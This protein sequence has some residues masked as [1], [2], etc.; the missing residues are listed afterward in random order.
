MPVMHLLK[1]VLGITTLVLVQSIFT[2]AFA[3]TPPSTV[4]WN[5]GIQSNGDGSYSSIVGG[6]VFTAT[7]YDTTVDVVSTQTMSDSSQ[8]STWTGG[9]S[10]TGEGFSTNWYTTIS[11]NNGEKLNYP[12]IFA[13][14]FSNNFDWENDF[15]VLDIWF[16]PI[17]FSVL[18]SSG[19]TAL[20]LLDG[21]SGQNLENFV[22]GTQNGGGFFKIGVDT[23][24]QVNPNTSAGNSSNTSQN[25]EFELN[26]T[27]AT[28]GVDQTTNPQL[29]ISTSQPLPDRLVFQ[30]AANEK[31][32]RSGLVSNS[33]VNGSD[34]DQ[35]PI[36]IYPTKD[37]QSF[38]LPF[39][40]LD[41]Q[42][43][44]N[45]EI[46]EICLFIDPQDSRAN[47][48]IG[49]VTF[50]DYSFID[51]DQDAGTT[52]VCWDFQVLDDDLVVGFDNA[53]SSVIEGDTGDTTVNLDISLAGGVST[54]SALTVPYTVSTSSTATGGGTD[55]TLSTSNAQI[56][57][58]AS[59]AQIS[60]TIE[61]DVL[62][63]VNEDIIITLSTPQSGSGY[64]LSSNSTTHTL[65]ITDNDA[66]PALSVADVTVSEGVTSGKATV[67]V[68]LD[69]VSG[70]DVQFDY[71][72]ADN[73]ATE[74]ADYTATS[75]SGVTIT[76]GNQSVTFDVTIQD[77]TLSEGDEDLTITLSNE[78]NA[79]LATSDASA[80]LTIEDNDGLPS[81]TIDSSVS[82]NEGLD[83]ET[84]QPNI[85]VR[86]STASSS[87]IT[88]N[89]RTSNGSATDLD[90]DVVIETGQ[91]TFQPNQTV[92]VINPTVFGDSIYEANETFTVELFNAVNAQISSSNSISIVNIIDDDPMPQI[93]IH[94]VGGVESEGIAQVEIKL[95][96][97]AGLDTRF[98]YRTNDI[99]AVNGT[100]YNGVTGEAVIL[101]GQDS[102]RI[103]IQLIDDQIDN[104]DREFTFEI[105]NPDYAV[106]GTSLSNF[107]ILDDDGLFVVSS[108]RASEEDRTITFEVTLQGPVADQSIAVFYEAIDGSANSASDFTLSSG[109]LNFNTSD[110]PP[111]ETPETKQ[112]TAIIND[113]LISEGVETFELRLFNVQST[114]NVVLP[115]SNAI[116]TIIDND[117][118]PILSFNNAISS[119]YENENT[120]TIGYQLSTASSSVVTAD[121]VITGTAS[122]DDY[123][124]ITNNIV[125]PP[126]ETSG[127]I[128]INGIEDDL[129]SEPDE[130]IIL[131]LSN[132]SSNAT[133][134]G[135]VHTYTI[136]DNDNL[137][138]LSFLANSSS[139][140]EA[141]SSTD[142]HVNL[143][144][145][146]SEPVT[147]D[148][149]ITGTA[150]P[151]GSDYS[152]ISNAILIPAGETSGLFSISSIIDD[153]EIENTETI[154]LT[155]SDISPNATLGQ[156]NHTVNI[157]DNDQPSISG[158]LSFEN[159]TSTVQ[160]NAG[161][162]RIKVNLSTIN[163]HDVSVNYTVSGTA[164]NPSD[165]N[166]SDGI[167]TIPAGES[168]ANIEIASIVNDEEYENIETI[169]IALFNPSGASLAS[170]LQIHEVKISDDE[171][172]PTVE[173][174][175]SSS[176][177]EEGAPTPQI[178]LVLEHE[179][180]TDITVEYLVGGT[181]EPN[182]IDHNL[183]SG[184]L[185]I[186][187]GESISMLPITGIVNDEVVESDETINITISN[188][189]G[190]QIGNQAT[191]Q[192]TIL[193]EMQTVMAVMKEA[194]D[195]LAEASDQLAQD[196]GTDMISASQNLIKTSLD[197]LISNITIDTAPGNEPNGQNTASSSSPNTAQ[198]FNSSIID[199]NLRVRNELVDAVSLLEADVNDFGYDINFGYDLN[200]PLFSKNM[201]VISKIALRTSK[202]KDGPKAFRLIGSVALEKRSD[203]LK[204]A[205]GRFIHF[206][207]EKADFNTSYKGTKKTKS[208][209][210]GLY[211]V[212]RPTDDD[213]KSIYLTAG[214]SDNDLKLKKGLIN[215]DSKYL[216]YQAQAGISFSKLYR[217]PRRIHNVQFATDFYADYQS[218]HKMAVTSGMSKFNRLIDGKLSYEF[219]ISFEPKTT[220]TMFDNQSKY[221][222]QF[223]PIIKCGIGSMKSNCGG[224][225]S[226][227]LNKTFTDRTGDF[228]IGYSMDRYRDTSSREFM[229]NIRKK[230]FRNNAVNTVTKF[231]VND[232]LGSQNANLNYFVN[233]EFNV[234][235]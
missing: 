196:R 98:A 40:L 61:G 148:V 231:G 86:L 4:D 76:A 111:F 87:T 3:Q 113:D 95:N 138:T 59:S 158:E 189:N 21:Y 143:S 32:D 103:P 112:I 132:V 101:K 125:I 10:L 114:G 106:L 177:G 182:G 48:P 151:G 203:D 107:E 104:A 118:L 205:K 215:L 25:M 44:E 75:S 235:F 9:T 178:Q 172:G 62:D 72:T 39:D 24:P 217:L 164:T 85:T 82:V 12:Y 207:R 232:N 91:I 64:T 159:S 137:P 109:V 58:G 79:T 133:L 93:D 55:Y 188:V 56:A 170:Q 5:S 193:G 141:I 136:K 150:T 90:N 84:A 209:A 127:Y 167:L 94:F 52:F 38:N 130:T 20:I 124:R 88:A 152:N 99:S 27:Q 67:T 57:A 80:T 13:E 234:K 81:L 119:G 140:S 145:E 227:N 34:F 108:P 229:F 219:L 73:T 51:E 17:D 210:L 54:A 65:T 42:I 128:T 29:Q 96:K 43:P 60:V 208:L 33:I 49:A 233:S 28:E 46:G 175:A 206:S 77:D 183:T 204:S 155:L 165:H 74:P 6:I 226:L 7:P 26:V 181:A 218:G 139:V 41:D 116:A 201:S 123:Y 212:Y 180:F 70:K 221:L 18:N 211:Q 131:T 117:S 147:A 31:R 135:N 30:V 168:S 154:I 115:T 174:S 184:T 69:A 129:V 126:G 146:S 50:V 16:S 121:L 213:M 1:A 134:F 187:Q 8:F 214:I 11:F 92:A 157:I 19:G 63:E 228:G 110:I 195:L 22:V 166:L 97:I 53:S 156:S 171:A 169:I 220:F 105:Y 37:S 47:P 197:N 162:H 15:E 216:S 191:H 190:G 36:T 173:F 199:E 198:G 160:E 230:P 186:P 176:E 122:H 224:G 68:S 163:Q 194:E 45:T 35:N 100:H 223:S 153:M 225:A 89:W 161:S 14:G 23:N 149:I 185:I 102:V 179:A 120:V 202:Q 192:Y 200:T 78:Q 144:S 142:I 66:E 2:P 222:L 71:T 83:G